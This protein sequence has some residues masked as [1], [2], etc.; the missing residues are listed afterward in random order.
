MKLY[1]IANEMLEILDQE[2]L[3]K[4]DEDRL[5]NTNM[6][7]NDKVEA[8]LQYRQGLIG[9]GEALVAEIKR[10]QAKRVAIER[11]AE[12]LKSYVMGTMQ[13]LG[14]GKFYG[15]T[16]TA[17]IAK[18]PPKVEIADDAELPDSFVRVKTIREPNKEA[19][20]ECNK[21]GYALPPGV[22]VTTSTHLRIS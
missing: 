5:T 4:E 17:T 21:L 3:S 20:L 15:V 2:E 7:F 1:E 12:W 14:L 13:G 22:S 9:H 10:L 6:E 19:L 16:M 11:R 18:S 8:V